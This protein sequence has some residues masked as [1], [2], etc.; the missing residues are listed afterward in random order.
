MVMHDDG[1]SNQLTGESYF[2]IDSGRINFYV[3]KTI[4]CFTVEVDNYFIN[5]LFHEA[6]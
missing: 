2:S 4:I 1:L 6:L 5:E 3:F